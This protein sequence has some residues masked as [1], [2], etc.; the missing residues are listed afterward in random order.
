MS[1]SLNYVTNPIKLSKHLEF[2]QKQLPISF[3]GDVTLKNIIT[4]IDE[5]ATT[6]PLSFAKKSY[7][8]ARLQQSKLAITLYIDLNKAH[9]LVDNI[10]N[11]NWDMVSFSDFEVT[12]ETWLLNINDLVLNR[13]SFL[14]RIIINKSDKRIKNLKSNDLINTINISWKDFF[15]KIFFKNK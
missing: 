3:N 11:K 2:I 8:Q 14:N 9:V 15:I 4:I 7:L 1:Y 12:I 13:D 10:K 5:Y 6:A